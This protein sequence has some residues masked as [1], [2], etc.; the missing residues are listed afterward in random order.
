MIT[1]YIN[2]DNHEAFETCSSRKTLSKDQ[3]L[4]AKYLAIIV[5][6]NMSSSI[7]YVEISIIINAAVIHDTFLVVTLFTAC[8]LCLF[9]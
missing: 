4:Q 1:L 7:I 5:L 2:V 3:L 8:Q 6:P 9:N